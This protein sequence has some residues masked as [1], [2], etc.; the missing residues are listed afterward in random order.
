MEGT[1]EAEVVRVLDGSA[2]AD[3]ADGRIGDTLLSGRWRRGAASC[4]RAA[5][6]GCRALT[7]RRPLWH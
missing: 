4:R 2:A 5:L 1:W 7:W 6:A 3:W